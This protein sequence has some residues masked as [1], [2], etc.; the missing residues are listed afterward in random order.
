MLLSRTWLL[1]AAFAVVLSMLPRDA[2]A[3]DPIAGMYDVQG[4]GVGGGHYEGVARIVANGETYEIL[5]KIGSDGYRGLGVATANGLAFAFSGAGFTGTNVVLYE[6][7]GPGVWCGV[8][9]AN[10][11][12]H[13]GREA[14]IRQSGD[15]AAK[16]VDCAQINASGDGVNALDREMAWND[17]DGHPQLADELRR[18]SGD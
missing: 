15:G 6:R 3:D 8:W 11:P 17:G 2:R 7:A 4:T 13:V 14:L 1:L 12:G 18:Q 10:Q 5:W 9:T 16:K